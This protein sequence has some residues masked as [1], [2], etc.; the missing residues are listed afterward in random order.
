M[1]IFGFK[2]IRMFK[3]QGSFHQL[4]HQTNFSPPKSEN[5]A[6]SFPI[7]HSCFRICY[8]FMYRILYSL[9]GVF[10]QP[11]IIFFSFISFFFSI[12][13]EAGKTETIIIVCRRTWHAIWTIYI[14]RIV[15]L[16]TISL[17]IIKRSSNLYICIHI[18]AS[19][20]EELCI[21]DWK[22]RPNWRS[23]DLQL[24]FETDKGEGLNRT[25]PFSCLE[26]SI[27]VKVNLLHESCWKGLLLA[28]ADAGKEY[29]LDPFKW[30]SGWS[31]TGSKLI[32]WDSS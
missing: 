31:N 3:G 20:L 14:Y 15:L 24:C 25:G 4:P 17:L 11:S 16:G 10:I 19:L 21:L 7:C 5:S 13:L 32:C 18:Y 28:A 26:L 29:H 9:L 22:L 8:W 6:S 2:P 1:E 23:K 30:E 27:W 12:F